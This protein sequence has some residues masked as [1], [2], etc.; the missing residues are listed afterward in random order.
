V[1]YTKA[2]DAIR[3]LFASTTE[4]QNRSYAAGHF[5]FNIPGG[6]CEACEGDGT[7]TVQMQFLADVELV[8]EECK[9]MR[10]KPGILEVRYK[11]K[12]IYDVLQ[13]TIRE[14]IS[15]FAAVPRV[16]NRLKFLRRW[17]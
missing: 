16:T 10:F 15:F 3:D 1:T 2:Y 4:A 12:N 17:A 14:A 11:G 13:M 5:S 9:G 7:V 8:C 6:R